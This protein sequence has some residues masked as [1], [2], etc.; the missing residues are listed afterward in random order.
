VT[1]GVNVGVSV[2]VIVGWHASP[3][4]FSQRLLP[5]G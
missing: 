2:T 3:S 4:G 1:V 5:S